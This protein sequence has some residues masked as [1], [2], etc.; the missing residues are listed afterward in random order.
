MYS[1]VEQPST[2]D[3]LLSE[4]KK[5]LLKTRLGEN[6]QHD[7]TVA[8]LM[9]A[10]ASA[11]GGCLDEF[12]RQTVSGDADVA[13]ASSVDFKLDLILSTLRAQDKSF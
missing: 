3:V 8:V 13:A 12:M 5:E 10:L 1:S 2:K 9:E 7:P 4:M 6:M 11:V